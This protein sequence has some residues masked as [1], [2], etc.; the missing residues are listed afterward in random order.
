MIKKDGVVLAAFLLY[1]QAIGLIG[2]VF[3]APAIP[4]WYATLTKPGLAPPDWIFAP[5]WITLFLCM[6]IAAFLVW[7]ERANHPKARL[8]LSLFVVQSVLNGLWSLLFFGLQ[9]PGSALIEIGFLWVAIFAT[10]VVF[11]GISRTAGML[12]LPYLAWVSFAA[13]LNTAFW[14]LN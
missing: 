4:G 1:S 7:R 11:W 12:F 10:L 5:V 3:T 9:S 6:G 14:M 8:A 2:S 13:Y